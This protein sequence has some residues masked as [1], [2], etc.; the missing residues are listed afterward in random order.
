MYLPKVYV[1]MFLCVV[2]IFKSTILTVWRTCLLLHLHCQKKIRAEQYCRRTVI[3]QYFIIFVIA[4]FLLFGSQN[5]CMCSN[6]CTCTFAC[7]EML[8]LINRW[9]L[10]G[11]RKRNISHWKIPPVVCGCMYAFCLRMLTPLYFFLLM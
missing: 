5:M 4:I 7:V 8:L 10:K 2:L 6:A 11:P 1:C 9:R 3:L